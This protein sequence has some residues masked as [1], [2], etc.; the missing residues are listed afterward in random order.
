MTDTLHVVLVGFGFAGRV[1]HAP[2]VKAT[3]GMELSAIVTSSTASGLEAQSK[4]PTARVFSSLDELLRA[5]PKLDLAVIATANAVHVQ[6][7]TWALRHELHAVVEK[8]LA[9]TA[10]S[11]MALEH[12]ARAHG[13][14]LHTFQNRR[15]D[16]D[17]LTLRGIASSGALGRI[18]RLESRMESYRAIARTGWRNSRNPTDLG[19]MLLDLGSH[20]I[21]QA[22]ILLG[23][24]SSVVAHN[25][26]VH[27]PS[28]PEDDVVLVL[29]HV[30]G[31]TSQLIASRAAAHAGPRFLAWGEAGSV[32]IEAVDSQEAALRAG[33]SPSFDGW[34]RA[35]EGAV[36][37]VRAVTSGLEHCQTEIP[38][39]DGQWHR[40]YPRVR[41]SISGLSSPP[42][43]IRD[44]M[45]NLR[46]LDAAKTSGESA[47]VQKLSPPASHAVTFGHD[48]RH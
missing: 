36:A 47:A 41:D 45:A 31:A 1:F 24:V 22:I 10:Q 13:R 40:F 46:V 34:E 32:R 17:F 26:S 35:N 12:C 29:T 8:P 21:D 38:F 25:R 33:Y 19:G 48:R 28:T 30:G 9:G 5:S 7:A 3:R 11:A 23:P 14:Q 20:L 43:P 15:W 37:Q 44:V 6:Q 18:Y 16:A 42:V 4:Y 2:L 27:D 39:V